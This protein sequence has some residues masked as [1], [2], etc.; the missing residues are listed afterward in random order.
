MSSKAWEEFQES[1]FWKSIEA[2]LKDWIDGVK[3]LPYSSEFS[4]R[5]E[6]FDEFARCQGRVEAMEYFLGLPQ[7]IANTLKYEEEDKDGPRHDEA[8][9]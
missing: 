1:S 7:T 2:N 9:G 3:D 6:R 8:G 5:E 4:T